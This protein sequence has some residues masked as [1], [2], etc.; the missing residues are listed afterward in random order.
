MSTPSR[1][2]PQSFPVSGS[3]QMSQFF[4]SAGQS[5][6]VSAFTSLRPMNIQDL[7]PLG[8]TALCSIDILI[9]LNLPVHEHECLSIFKKYFL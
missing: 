6:G 1:P 8:W 5:V 4:T 3:F 2:A 9:I 7:S